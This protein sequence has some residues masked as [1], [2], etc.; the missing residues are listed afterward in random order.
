MWRT[1]RTLRPS[2]LLAAVALV[3]FALVG[4]V[5]CAPAKGRPGSDQKAMDAIAKQIQTTLSQRPDVV[6]AEV[7]YQNNLNASERAD[8]RR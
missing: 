2:S 6:N 8:V 3:A 4:S 1:R 7:G 5:A